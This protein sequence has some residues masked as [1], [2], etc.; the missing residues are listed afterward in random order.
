MEA[1]AILMAGIIAYLL[2]FTTIKRDGLIE[3]LA[4]FLIGVWLTG[5]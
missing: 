2:A 4:L 3:I 5:M 1:V